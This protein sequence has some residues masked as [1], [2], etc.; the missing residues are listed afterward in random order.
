MNYYTQLKL[1]LE[2]PR[3]FGEFQAL[4]TAL[5]NNIEPVNTKKIR[6]MTPHD[7]SPTENPTRYN[8]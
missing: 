4:R 7:T 8:I 5:E 6:P 2:M 3:P 1:D